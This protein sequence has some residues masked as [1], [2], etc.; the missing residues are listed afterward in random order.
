M[1]PSGLFSGTSAF[2]LGAAEADGDAV[3]D[4]ALEDDGAADALADDEDEPE[5][6]ALFDELL[7]EHPAS[8]N[9]TS[10]QAEIDEM[11]FDMI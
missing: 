2:S 4:G 7:L 11:T 5:A 8:N 3:S 1:S 10:K 6:A 9:P